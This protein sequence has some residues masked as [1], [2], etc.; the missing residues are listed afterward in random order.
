MTFDVRCQVSS[1]EGWALL[2]GTSLIIML[3]N[4]FIDS[5]FIHSVVKPL[6]LLYKL[7]T[8]VFRV[9]TLSS[10]LH[11][12]LYLK[13]DWNLAQ[14]LE[15]SMVRYNISYSSSFSLNSLGMNH[16][17]DHSSCAGRSHIMSGEWVKGRNPSDLSWSSCSRDDLE[18][19]LK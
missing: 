14:S 13:L 16:D 9:R 11:H 8:V 18:N 15:I 3:R 4:S 2:T 7:L 10:D 19:F 6:H 1:S 12:S 5:F 17:D